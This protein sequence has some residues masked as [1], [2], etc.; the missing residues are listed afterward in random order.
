VA[1]ERVVTQIDTLVGPEDK[2]GAERTALPPT[3]LAGHRGAERFQYLGEIGKGGMGSVHSVRDPFLLRVT[4]M[5]VLSPRLLARPGEVERFLREARITAQLDH[6]NIVP[7]HEI[8]TDARGNFYFT[9]KKVDGRTLRAWIAEVREGVGQPAR[10]PEALRAMVQAFLKICDAVA[11]AH[12][13]GVIHCDL[14][15]DNVMVGAFGQ[16][17][18][19]DWGL[20]RVL[21]ERQPAAPDG[22]YPPRAG[23][24]PAGTPSFMSPE[25]A[26]GG[27]LD[28][29]TDVF[30][31]GAMLYAILVGVPPFEADDVERALAEAR[32]RAVAFSADGAHA[33]APRLREIVLRAT[34]REPVERYSSVLA[35]RADV[36]AA[37]D[38]YP[39]ATERNAAGAR[40]VV[41]GQPGDCA[42]I[43]VSGSCVAYKT[44]E[45]G[46]RVV[47]RRLTPGAVFGETAVLSGGIRTATVEAEDDV[48][49]NVVSRELLERNV[50]LGTP[51]GAFVVALADRFRELEARLSGKRGG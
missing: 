21:S 43:L 46:A 42:Y 12:S 37:L 28:E 8:G 45:G 31:L 19:M 26:F 5:K 25:Q 48:V 17:Y 4:A 49:V 29:R 16:V 13:R 1:G 32:E 3:D 14:K 39:F 50:G 7:V 6:P 40:I 47:L 51:F 15:P 23:G 44:G 35:L 11:F 20:A 36:E 22:S 27:D 38:A 18:L 30:G 24:S 41:E 10:D 33:I 34:A 9:M 2:T